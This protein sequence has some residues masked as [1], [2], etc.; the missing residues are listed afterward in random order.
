M[1]S[2]PIDPEIARIL[3]SAV[4][5]VERLEVLLVLRRER[6]QA[7]T[8]KALRRHVAVNGS[9]DTHLAILCGRGF[10]GVNL[11]ND[12]VY[13]YQPISPRIDHQAEEIAALWA[14]RRSD[15][16][17]LLEGRATTPAQD[18]ADAF[19]LG[20]KRDDQDG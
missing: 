18:F 8:A 6:P 4:E 9:L 13:V 20:R 7:F 1:P 19:R 12:L 16:E 17:A 10:L 14:S 3:T 2:N 15:V 5:S 11:G